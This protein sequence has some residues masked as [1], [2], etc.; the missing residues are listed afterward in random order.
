MSCI[1]NT[2]ILYFSFVSEC[3]A[4][5]YSVTEKAK[6]EFANLDPNLISAGKV[7]VGIV[8]AIVVVIFFFCFYLFR[9]CFSLSANNVDREREY[10]ST[11][12]RSCLVMLPITT[13]FE[14][15]SIQ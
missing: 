2:D 3:G 6:A 15:D 8:V 14:K 7:F 13:N 11:K 12:I 4:S 9:Q 10:R 1:E 5:V